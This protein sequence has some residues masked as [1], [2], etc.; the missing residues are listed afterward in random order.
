LDWGQHQCAPRGRCQNRH[1]AIASVRRASLARITAG[2][3]ALAYALGALAVARG[4]GTFSTYAGRSQLAAAFAVLAGLALAVAGVVTSAG[5]TGRRVGDLALTASFL[6]FASVWTGWLGGPV[7]VRSLGMVAAGFTFP[8]LLHLTL[9]YP[10]GR[11]RP[12][13]VRWLVAAVYLEAVVSALGRALFRDPFFVLNC[14]DNCTDNAFLVRSVPGLAR[15]IEN[16]DLWV[17]FAAGAAL[18]VTCLWRVVTASGPARRVLSP[19]VLPAVVVAAATAAHSITLNRM[20]SE[21]PA[22]PAFST[23]FFLLCG[24]VILLASGLL[25]AAVRARIQRRSVARI[26]AGLGEAPAPGSLESALARA[27]GDPKLR[28]TYWLHDSGRYVNAHGQPVT[29]PI[30][31]AGRAA[32]PLVRDGRTVAVVSH[33]AAVADIEREMGAAVR[34][35]LENERL[36]AEV[37]S[38]LEDLR[39][40]RA[41][42]VETGDAE[43]RRLERDLHDGAQQRLLAL[44]YD[45]RLA[46]A[47]A[48]GEGEPRTASILLEATGEAQAALGELRELAHG[49]YPAILTEAGLAPALAT[50]ADQ[51]G[52]PVEI[53]GIAEDRYPAP[54]ETAAYLVVADGLDDAA[55]R[56]A[57]YAA[58]SERVSPMIHLVDR[59]GALDGILAVGANTLLADIPCA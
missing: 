12:R 3:I 58:V 14:W 41:R 2:S 15:A 39:A 17:G 19:V 5:R 53:S 59:V 36:Q 7:L 49:I 27:V 28:I 1:V 34:L 43:R 42:V 40:S 50:L 52:I 35:A 30:N 57:S 54:V 33:A 26:V 18:V 32:T 16:I 48:E 29:E 46:R 11:L 21:D 6:W 38:Q 51:A 44:S 47:G 8:V 31:A 55:A 23:I 22:D 10:S 45:L 4:P 37:L 13:V 24:G 20:P 9:A 56:G 25:W